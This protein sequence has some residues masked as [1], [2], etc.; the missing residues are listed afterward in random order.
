LHNPEPQQLSKVES[1]NKIVVKIG[2][3]VWLKS[4]DGKEI[5]IACGTKVPDT[6]FMNA[7]SGFVKALL[8]KEEGDQVKFGNGFEI[9]KID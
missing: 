8:G 4:I 5:K 2:S 3:V 6:Q 9:L 7:E 1:I